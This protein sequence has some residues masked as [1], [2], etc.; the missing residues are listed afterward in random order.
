MNAMI[1]IKGE[2]DAALA[3]HVPPGVLILLYLVAGFSMSVVGYS[4]GLAGTRTPGATMILVL[5]L[6]LVILAIVDLDRPRRGL[7]QVRQTSLIE[8]QRSLEGK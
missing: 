1:D 5:L 4:N 6:G 8:L 3:N 7:I 2:N